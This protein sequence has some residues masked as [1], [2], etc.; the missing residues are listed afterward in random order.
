VRFCD[1]K[2]AYPNQHEPTSLFLSLSF[3]FSVAGYPRFFTSFANQT[4]NTGAQKKAKAT[5]WGYEMILLR[6]LEFVDTG[7]KGYNNE[8][9]VSSIDLSPSANRSWSPISFSNVFLPAANATVYRFSTV[10]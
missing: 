3:V 8:T 9:V 5:T 2:F 6:I 4:L 10:S 1:S 7:D